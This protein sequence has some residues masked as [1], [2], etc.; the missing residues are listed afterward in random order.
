MTYKINKLSLRLANHFK[1]I[2]I[3]ILF[4]SILFLNSESGFSMNI[5]NEK[6]LAL[7]Y[8]DSKEKNLFKG[9]DNE[10]LLKYEYFF[11]SINAEAINEIEGLNNFV[12][13]VEKNCSY[14]LNIKE[15]NEMN[16][17]LNNFFSREN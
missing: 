4:I 2:L 7:R 17:L 6:N 14:K 8:C 15:Q 1:L 3:N 5:N 13:E 12:S 9:L 10:R 16:E 11:N